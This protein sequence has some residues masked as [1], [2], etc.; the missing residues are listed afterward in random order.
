MPLLFSYG[1]LQ[2]PEVQIATFDR[3]LSGRRDHLPGYVVE[4][5][6]IRNPA[7]AA[8]LGIEAHANAQATGDPQ[9]RIDGTVFDVTEDELRSVDTYEH[10]DAYARRSV[11]LGSGAVAWIYVYE[12]A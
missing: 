10:R 2:R 6:S 7:R 11:T 4:R 1:S 3:L 12:G 8:E 5:V 9:D